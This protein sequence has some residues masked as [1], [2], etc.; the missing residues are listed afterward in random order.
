MYLYLDSSCIHSIMIVEGVCY[1]DYQIQLLPCPFTEQIELELFVVFHGQS[2]NV[3]YVKNRK[4]ILS[5]KFNED[6]SK[7]CSSLRVQ[8]LLSSSGTLPKYRMGAPF[9]TQGPLRI[10]FRFTDILGSCGEVS[11]Q[12]SWTEASLVVPLLVFQLARHR[13]NGAQ[14]YPAYVQKWRSWRSPHM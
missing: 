10:S 1:H 11:A 5:Y 8:I 7:H 13:A 6:T 12:G 2:D 4:K 9:S 3:S 14:V